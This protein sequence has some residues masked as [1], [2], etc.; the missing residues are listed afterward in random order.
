MTANEGP[1]TAEQPPERLEEASKGVRVITTQMP[2][3]YT[4]PSLSLDPPAAPE[5]PQ[6]PAA[7]SASGANA[8]SGDQS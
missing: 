4:P 6:T 1:R 3:D 7:P 5:A 8:D 2:Q